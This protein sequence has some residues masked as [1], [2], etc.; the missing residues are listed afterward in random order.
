[1]PLVEQAM[2]LANVI[3]E[4][5]GLQYLKEIACQKGQ[6]PYGKYYGRGYI[7]LTWDYNYH[8]ASKDLFGDRRLLR[9]P[10]LVTRPDL[11]WATAL[12]Y[13][14]KHVLPALI[15]KNAIATLSLG[16]AVSRINGALECGS[17]PSN[18]MGAEN[19][20]RIFNRILVI[21]GITSKQGTLEGCKEALGP[22]S[23]I[24]KDLA[25]AMIKSVSESS[26]TI[27][28]TITNTTGTTKSV[29]EKVT[30]SSNMAPSATLTQRFNSIKTETPT[31]SGPA[32][33]VLRL[34]KV[35]LG[36]TSNATH[37]VQLLEP[38]KTVSYNVIRVTG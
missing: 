1:M 34:A 5:G 6:C 33:D 3:W 2:F 29:N 18:I 36:V 24:P 31:I 19:R 15:E 20:L 38:T 8:S 35:T 13:W 25:E 4:S 16:Y 17:K 23:K 11:A 37:A 14:R 9:F 27:A 28:M 7:Q 12:W 30:G 22:S 26:S 21:W 32:T 10:D